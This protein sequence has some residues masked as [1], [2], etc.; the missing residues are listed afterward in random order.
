MNSL[1]I[2][3]ILASEF[4]RKT[5]ENLMEDF[6]KINEPW[7]IC[8]EE[9]GLI[10]NF[11]E[12]AG[13]IYKGLTDIFDIETNIFKNT[14]SYLTS[15][16]VFSEKLVFLLSEIYEKLVSKLKEFSFQSFREAISVIQISN[17]I[18]MDIKASIDI[19]EKYYNSKA[20]LLTP[21]FIG[22]S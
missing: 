19:T 8:T 10:Q 16:A 11:G 17:N 5:A 2:K 15:R 1:E 18:D 12:E 4:C 14:Q 7:K 3:E 20:K 6:K 13:K 9:G 22:N 21:F